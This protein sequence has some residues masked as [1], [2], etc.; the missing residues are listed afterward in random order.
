M[1]PLVAYSIRRLLALIPTLIVITAITFFMGFAAPGDPVTLMLGD[2]ARTDQVQA[3]KQQYGLD[4]PPVI[5]Y[6]RYAVG[7]VKG[8]LG[9][10]YA[11]RGRPVKD[12][13]LKAFTVSLKLG[14]AA[15]LFAWSTGLIL[16]ILAAVYRGRWLDNLS[17][18][19]AVVGVS[20]PVF[21]EA[22]ALMYLFGVYLK[23]LPAVGWGEPKHFILPAIVLGTRSAAIIARITRS[24]MLDVLNQDYIRTAR[25]KGLSGQ[26]VTL[27]H[28]VKNAM[29][30]VMTVL[31]TTLGT[32]L[33]GAFI[34]ETIFG[35]PGI[36][37]V[38]LQAIFQ[39][40]YPV[41]QATVMLFA[42]VFVLVNLIVDLMYGVVD[43]RIRF[44]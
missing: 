13:I 10:S 23:V 36:G 35:I 6:V 2:K 11:Y 21:V 31:G 3:L 24:S 37:R 26:R 4:K 28:A 7:V 12:I 9:L 5:Q 30:P 27:K 38:S 1:N 34:T 15:A 18:L 42:T 43:P 19:L 40:D 41:I 16:G 33:T 17:M 44:S 22:I 39:R 29:I 25:A 14:G 8:D 32:L 20:L